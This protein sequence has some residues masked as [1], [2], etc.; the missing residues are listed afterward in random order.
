MRL[1]DRYIARAILLP[2]TLTLAVLLVL[3]SAYQFIDEQSNIGQGSYS[4][5]DAVKFV[6]LSLPQQIFELAPAATLVGAMIGLGELSRRSE[7]VAMRAAGVS[8]WRLLLTLAGVGVLVVTF[9]ALVGEYLAPQSTAIA[10]QSRASAR[11]QHESAVQGAIWVHQGDSYLRIETSGRRNVMPRVTT[12]EA[13]PDGAAL[14]SIGR[15]DNVIVGADGGWLLN[16]YRRV[17]YGERRL[18]EAIEP[19]FHL[20]MRAGNA[21]LDAAT[22]PGDRSIEE[23]LTL[24]RQFRENHQDARTFVFALWSRVAHS[25]AALWCVL[26]ALPFAF[27]NLRAAKA[28][29]RVFVAVGIGMVFVL[30]QQ[31]VE[32]GAMISSLPPAVL[33]WLPTAALAVVSSIL[34]LRVR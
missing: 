7:I 33:A 16:Q 27:G 25:V 30:C 26:L 1:L 17:L 9:D 2:S 21:L 34:V 15:S 11:T 24:I 19:S 31:L 4:M 29:V 23:L 13:V 8:V 32:S 10:F 22:D 20:Q 18:T 3:D 28:G 14:A 12:F 6:L 5:L